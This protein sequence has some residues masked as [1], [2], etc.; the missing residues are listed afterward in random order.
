[1]E[2]RRLD[3]H[4]G[5]GPV[6]LEVH[7]DGVQHHERGRNLDRP[8]P[9]RDPVEREAHEEVD[10]ERAGGPD[11][12]R[13]APADLVGERTR[14]QERQSVDPRADGEDLPELRLGHERIAHGALGHGQVVPAHVEKGVRESQRD[15]VQGSANPVGARVRRIVHGAPQRCVSGG[16]GGCDYTGCGRMAPLLARLR[17]VACPRRDGAA[18]PDLDGGIPMSMP[19]GFPARLAAAAAVSFVLFMPAGHAQQ[20]ARPAPDSY[21]AAALALHRS[22]GQPLLGR[23]R[24]SRRPAHLLRRRRL[25]R[26]LQDDRRRRP[27]AADL[28]RPAGRR[29]SG[30][31]PSR[32][33]TPTSSGPAPARA[34]SAATSRSARASTSR[35][36]PGKTWTLMGLE[37]TGRIPRLVDRPEEPGR[38][39]RV[40]ARPRLRPAAGA[41]RLPHDRRRQDVDEDAVRGREHR[42]LGHRDGPPTTRASSS[43]GCGSSRSTPGAGRAAGRAAGSTRRA[44]AAP[45]WKKLDRPRPADAARRQGGRGHLAL[46]PEPRLRADRDRRRRAVGRQARPTP[47]SSSAATTAARAGGW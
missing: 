29:R 22:R 8:A 46:E 34:R 18:P 2:P 39:A 5:D 3:R 13:G 23:G 44:T 11:Q 26:H 9:V 6:A 28:R 47:A 12:H 20:A 16:G 42:L 35:P 19:T 36:T 24:H 15:P 31:S 1:M 45:T 38:R 32:P 27:L 17:G 14:E 40:R 4:D 7:V 21:G 41:R 10:H 33:P 25:G 30:R 37:Q 43:P